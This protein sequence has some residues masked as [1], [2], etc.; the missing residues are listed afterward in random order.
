MERLAP[1]KYYDEEITSLYNEW[2][3]NNTIMNQYSYY[4][5]LREIKKVQG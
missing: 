5:T 3:S 4:S 1:I 2:V